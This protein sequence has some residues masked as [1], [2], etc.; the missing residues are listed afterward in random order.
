MPAKSRVSNFSVLRHFTNQMFHC[1]K[2]SFHHWTSLYVMHSLGVYL[3]HARLYCLPSSWT[4]CVA[5]LTPIPIHIPIPTPPLLSLLTWNRCILRNKNKTETGL[6]DFCQSWP[7]T[8]C[9]L[10]TDCIF[11]Q[12]TFFSGFCGT[13]TC[14][15]VWDSLYHSAGKNIT[16]DTRNM[17]E[18]ALANFDVCKRLNVL[19]SS[20]GDKYGWIG[21]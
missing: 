9:D 21:E 16:T 6:N 19:W 14:S 1:W 17:L 18:M 8:Q 12:V 3:T 15:L 5:S 2:S 10:H 4:N 7:V 20:A 11:H 13:A